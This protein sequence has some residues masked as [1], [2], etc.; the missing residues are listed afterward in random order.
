MHTR[1]NFPWLVVG[2]GTAITCFGLM[3]GMKLPGPPSPKNTAGRAPNFA[4]ILPSSPQEAELWRQWWAVHGAAALYQPARG[5]T[6]RSSSS[7]RPDALALGREFPPKML[8]V[9]EGPASLKFRSLDPPPTD[10]VQALAL[11]EQPEATPLALSRSDLVAAPLAAR[12]AAV[13]VVPTSG[14]Q[15]VLQMELLDSSAGPSG[16]WEPFELIG[17]ISPAG[18]VGGLV[19]LH[20]SGLAEV[21]R[22]FRDRLARVERVGERLPPGTYVFRIAP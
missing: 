1:A 18:L 13:A 7:P 5:A 22:Y 20:S 19:V 4:L 15:P 2:L 3:A 10:L 14:S 17:T 16:T 6:D 12:I 21:N 9:A 8:S 11:T